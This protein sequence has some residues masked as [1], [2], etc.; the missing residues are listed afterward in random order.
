MRKNDAFVTEIL[1][2]RQTKISLAIIAVAERLPT[3]ATLSKGA[4]NR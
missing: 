1:N 2:M 3:S 4:D